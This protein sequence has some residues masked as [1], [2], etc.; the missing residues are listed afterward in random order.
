MLRLRTEFV[1]TICHIYVEKHKPYK[2]QK[3]LAAFASRNPSTGPRG[4]EILED[5]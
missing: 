2:Y 1:E 3:L 5:S 4:E